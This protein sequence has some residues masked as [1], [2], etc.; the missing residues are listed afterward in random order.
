KASDPQT[1]RRELQEKR[2]KQAAEVNVLKASDAELEQALDNL[3]ANVRA[4]ETQA[5]GARQAAAAAQ[6]AAA[7]ARQVQERTAA[8]LEQLRGSMRNVAVDAY[9]R[10]PSQ[11]TMLPFEAGTLS[12][13]ATRQYLVD[14]ALGR[15]TDLAD[16]LRAT[17][18]DLE[19]QRAAADEAAARAAARRKEVDGRL[20]EVKQALDTKQQVADSVEERLERALAEADSLAALDKQLAAEIAQR[21]AA[22]AARIASTARPGRAT[23]AAAPQGGS[24]SVTT[25]RG[26]TVAT[27]IAGQLEDLFSAAEADGFAL[28]GSGYRNSD[29]QVAVRRSNC[30]SSN[31]DIYER[32][33]SSCRPPTARPGQSMH[34]RGLAVDFTWNGALISSRN[35]AFQ[36]L[37]RNAGRYGLANLPREPWHW[38]TNGN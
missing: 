25:V 19:T 34:E 2:A 27:S 9:V 1:K 3:D 32:P 5:A 36:W 10:G 23:R 30:G 12:E 38:S 4:Q 17:G 22:L 21:Q 29:G 33:A 28:G 35:A 37:S 15:S 13:L 6:E 26:I 7:T 18:E 14:V 20:G 24:V 31:Y 11:E 16:E 8:R